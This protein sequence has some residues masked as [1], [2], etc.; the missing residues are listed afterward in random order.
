MSQLH[1]EV[2][3]YIAVITMDNPPVNAM[4]RDWNMIELLDSFA[5]RDDVRVCILTGA[6]HARLLRGRRREARGA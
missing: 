2:S 4:D 6:G 3:D 5:D 1:L